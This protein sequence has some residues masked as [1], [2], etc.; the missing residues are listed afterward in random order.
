MYFPNLSI[1]LCKHYETKLV[2]TLCD[3]ELYNFYF[4]NLVK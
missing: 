2:L 3:S 4:H 1:E